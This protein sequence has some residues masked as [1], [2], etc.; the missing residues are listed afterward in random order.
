MSS[1][2]IAVLF[3]SFFHNHDTGTTREALVTFALYLS[4][5]LFVVVCLPAI[6][7]NFVC[8]SH[9]DYVPEH[10]QGIVPSFTP[11][12]IW[13]YGLLAILVVITV[14]HLMDILTPVS[15]IVV[16]SILLFFI[17]CGYAIPSFYGS[18]K[19]SALGPD[20]MLQPGAAPVLAS[21]STKQISERMVEEGST[22]SVSTSDAQPSSLELPWYDAFRYIKLWA[23]LPCTFVL[24]GSS[25]LLFI[26]INSI[27][28]SLGID[29]NPGFVALL[30]LGS[31]I[32]QVHG[33]SLADIVHRHH[34]PRSCI[35]FVYLVVA[36]GNNFLLSIGS[37]SYLYVGLVL[38]TLCTRYY[39]PACSGLIG[40]YFGMTHFA[41]NCGI[42]GAVHASST[43]FYF[44]WPGFII[45]YR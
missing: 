8:P 38:G 14:L 42:S 4:I 30:G 23:L 9:I 16:G 40:D 2:V 13:S 3:G 36:A 10:A 39:L 44:G 19:V 17:F 25:S 34:I 26:N 1:A 37:T 27:V 22:V 7:S 12:L 31:A 15:H 18:A 32:S 6:P 33:G 35:A 5:V 11:V 21:P 24:G 43:F 41:L 29:F 45:L 20:N 28:V